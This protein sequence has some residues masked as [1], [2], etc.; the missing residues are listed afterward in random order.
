M[1]NTIGRRV[2]SIGSGGEC[3]G[4]Y[5]DVSEKNTIGRR[6]R[7]YYWEACVKNTFGR[8]E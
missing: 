6:A 2:R 1:E 3:E 4:Y 8:R 7:K 5:L